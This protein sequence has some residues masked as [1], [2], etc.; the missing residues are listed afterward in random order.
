MSEIDDQVQ[1]DLKDMKAIFAAGTIVCRNVTFSD[2]AG[3]HNRE[4]DKLMA[5]Y[6]EGLASRTNWIPAPRLKWWQ[7]LMKRMGF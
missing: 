5:E 3:P 4:A 2:E 6:S 7:R 1:H